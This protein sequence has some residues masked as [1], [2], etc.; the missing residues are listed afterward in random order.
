MQRCFYLIALLLVFAGCGKEELS[1][2]SKKVN[3]TPTNVTSA[4]NRSNQKVNVCHYDADS[5]SWHMINISINALPAHLNHGDVLLEDADGDGW[6]VEE[7]ECVPGGD[8]HDEDATINPGAEE[9]CDDGI[10]NNCNGEIDEDCVD[11]CWAT[12]YPHEF[13]PASY[14]ERL[15]AITGN[16]CEPHFD[17]YT[18]ICFDYCSLGGC[19]EFLWVYGNESKYVC[20]YQSRTLGFFTIDISEEEAAACDRQMAAIARHLELPDGTNSDC[21][22][23]FDCN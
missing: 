5:D 15:G 9:L 16:G 14:I 23:V 6:V 19:V 3:V 1:L 12:I 21:A 22:F 18:R 2:D 4:Q 17:I 11:C 10:D 13:G 20:A 8:C 7:N